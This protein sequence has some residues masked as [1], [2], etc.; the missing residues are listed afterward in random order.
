ME[1]ARAKDAAHP[2]AAEQ[3]AE[4]KPRR[5]GRMNRKTRK[6]YDDKVRK[7]RMAEEQERIAE[8]LMRTLM[9]VDLW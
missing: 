2:A 9:Y 6:R 7:E 8:E 1:T 3:A 4:P 5:K